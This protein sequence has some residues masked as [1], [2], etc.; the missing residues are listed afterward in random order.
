MG[1]S[2]LRDPSINHQEQDRKASKCK[3]RVHLVAPSDMARG[4]SS[5]RGRFTRYLQQETWKFNALQYASHLR[6]AGYRTI[7]QPTSIDFAPATGAACLLHTTIPPTIIGSNC[8][9]I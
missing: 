6:C 5:L 7:K 3:Q 4:L 8:M 2:P 1:G 9:E